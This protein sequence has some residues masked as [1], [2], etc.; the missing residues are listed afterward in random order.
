MNV[1][2]GRKVR[3][4]A[5]TRVVVASLVESRINNLPLSFREKRVEVASVRFDQ[6]DLVGDVARL[7]FG[8]EGGELGSG[9][10]QFARKLPTLQGEREGRHDAGL[11]H[12]AVDR[13]FRCVHLEPNPLSIL[14]PDGYVPQRRAVLDRRLQV[15]VSRSSVS[16]RA[17]KRSSCGQAP[18][19][20]KATS[21]WAS[22]SVMRPSSDWSSSLARGISTCSAR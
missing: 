22:E 12:R 3:Q 11:G 8:P 21:G 16:R 20:S 4:R 13:R 19:S 9:R 2:F 10:N 7:Q 18:N 6:R 5:L 1:E 14:I 17:R 15:T